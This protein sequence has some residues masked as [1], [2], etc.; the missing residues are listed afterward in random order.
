M[1]GGTGARLVFKV[2]IGK[3]VAVGVAGRSSSGRALSESSTNSA[4]NCA[5]NATKGL[6]AWRPQLLRWWRIEKRCEHSNFPRAPVKH[7]DGRPMA[8]SLNGVA[9]L[10]FAGDHKVSRSNRGVGPDL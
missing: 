10:R 7:I 2:S 6:A 3:R 4:P 8:L 5:L 9:V 1:R